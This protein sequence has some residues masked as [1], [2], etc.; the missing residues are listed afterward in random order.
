MSPYLEMAS[1]C[2]LGVLT[3]ACLV[4]IGLLVNLYDRIFDRSGI[5]YE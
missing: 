5:D 3:G 2:L 1:D 4:L